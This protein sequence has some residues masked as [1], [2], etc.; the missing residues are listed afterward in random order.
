MLKICEADNQYD[1]VN[2]AFKPISMT[3][4]NFLTHSILQIVQ[5]DRVLFVGP[6]LQSG[7]FART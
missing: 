7:M 5:D 2:V 4:K 6:I 3:Y 1:L